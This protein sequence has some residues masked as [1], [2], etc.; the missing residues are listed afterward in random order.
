[1]LFDIKVPETKV[2]AFDEPSVKVPPDKFDP[3]VIAEFVT[4]ERM[5]FDNKV[6]FIVVDA[7][8]DPSVKVPPDKLEPIVIAIVGA[9]V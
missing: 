9:V 1:M 2:D 3:I 4:V 6:P 7:F 8:T 5:L